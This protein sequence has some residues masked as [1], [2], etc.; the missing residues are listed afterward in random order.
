MK[1][2]LEYFDQAI[3]RD[4]TYTLAYTGIA[5][6]YVLLGSAG[7]DVLTPNDAMM[8]AETAANKALEIDG[9]LA[10]AHTSVAI[11]KVQY[12]WNWAEG[13]SR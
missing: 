5:D 12:A 6:S 3:A 11:I 13:E 7:Y 2:S 10:E 1:K 4:P 8:K 9:A